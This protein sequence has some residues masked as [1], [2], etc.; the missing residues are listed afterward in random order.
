VGWNHNRH[1]AHTDENNGLRIGFLSQYGYGSS[2]Q[3]HRSYVNRLKEI[4]CRNT[5]RIKG[6]ESETFGQKQY[7]IGCCRRFGYI[8][9]VRRMAFILKA[10]NG[11]YSV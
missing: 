1:P 5:Q 3:K 6:N 8:F 7:K 10:E 2:R 9:S 11:G 4:C